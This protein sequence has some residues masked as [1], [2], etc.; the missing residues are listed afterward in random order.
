MLRPSTTL[1]LLLL[2]TAGV[3]PARAQSLPEVERVPGLPGHVADV[4]ASGARWAVVFED[5]SVR[6]HQGGVT[7]WA[8]RAPRS[9]LDDADDAVLRVEGLLDELAD[10]AS[11]LGSFEEAPVEDTDVEPADDASGDEVGDAAAD[12]LEELLQ[13]ETSLALGALRGSGGI[14]RWG[15]GDRIAVS[16][17]DG[18]WVSDDAGRRWSRLTRDHAVALADQGTTWAALLEDGQVLVDGRREPVALGPL[19]LEFRDLAAADGT[20]WAATDLGL[21]SWIPGRGWSPSGDDLDPL[22][23]VVADPGWEGGLWVRGDGGFRRTDDGGVTWRPL[24]DGPVRGVARWGGPAPG[25]ALLVSGDGLWRHAEGGWTRD[26]RQV[27]LAKIS[28]AGLFALVDGQLLAP[29]FAWGD[30]AGVVP[31]WV[32]LGHLLGTALGRR[33]LNDSLGAGRIVQTLMPELTIQGRYTHDQDISYLPYSTAGTSGALS[34]MV[35]LTWTPAGRSD[36]DGSFDDTLEEV[37]LRTGFDDLGIGDRGLLGAM[38]G[39]VGRQATAYRNQLA[40]RITELHAARNALFFERAAVPPRNLLEEVVWELRRSELE[41]RI[42]AL[43]DGAV[44]SWNH[45]RG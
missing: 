37:A 31:A 28:E 30:G 14:V 33:E 34:L 22:Y 43:T 42:D 39:R 16:R 40:D 15:V 36:A 7:D 18:V 17:S 4:D 26:G 32:P 44:S 25:G 10:D 2:A 38:G 19:L 5:G 45:D 3:T 23:A 6:V 9:V 8:L 12:R 41:A 13:G 21:W 20:V 11:D 35:R 24:G 27:D 1:A 29:P